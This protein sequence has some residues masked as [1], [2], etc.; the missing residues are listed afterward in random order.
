MKI[1]HF[2]NIQAALDIE[3][4]SQHPTHKVGAYICGKDITGLGFSVARSNFWPPILSEKIGRDQKLGNASTTVHAEIAAILDAPLTEGADI[5]ITDLPC[6]N[7]TKAI[8]EARIKNVYIDSHT[9]N[10]P[11]GLKIK[12]YFE[13][14][15]IPIFRAAGIGV[16]EMNIKT[17]EYKTLIEPDTLSLRPIQRPVHHIPLEQAQINHAHFLALI[18]EISNKTPFAACYVKTTLGQYTFLYARTHRSIGLTSE[19]EN[20]LFNEGKN[21]Y[22]PTIQPLNRLLLTCARYGLKIDPHYLY[23]SQVPTSREFVNLIGAGYKSLQIGDM[24]TSRDTHGL[25]ALG[26]IKKHKIIE[27][28]S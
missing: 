12:P 8:I 24:N 13:D 21:K 17:R 10:T 16:Y 28:Q 27:I 25:T 23:S 2:T 26:Q 4:Q 3:N 20:T 7:C 1:N 15:S 5:Y 18:E 11:L 19:Q 14:V 22:E 9:H 6:P